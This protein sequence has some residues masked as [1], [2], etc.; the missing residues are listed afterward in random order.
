M[1]CE[2]KRAE[3]HAENAEPSAEQ[4]EAEFQQP[5]RAPNSS[6]GIAS[7]QSAETATTTTV[8][9]LTRLAETAASPMISRPQFRSS[10]Q[11]APACAHRP[12][13]SVQ[14]QF[15]QKNFQNAGERN[16]FPRFGERQQEFGRKHLRVK[17]V[18]ARYPPEIHRARKT[19]AYR[20][21]RSNETIRK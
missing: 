13:G 21:S 7:E 8:I 5:E 20:S 1:T 4:N 19:A 17:P 6:F 18:T 2:K 10:R 12:R 14:K 3:H 9:G 15:H 16:A 11:A